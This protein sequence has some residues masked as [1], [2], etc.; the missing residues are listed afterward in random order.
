MQNQTHPQTLVQLDK[1]VKA[2]NKLKDGELVYASVKPHGKTMIEL[3]KEVEVVD[4]D[5]EYFYDDINLAI[6]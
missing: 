5:A 4:L 3:I 1:A 6:Q 2:K